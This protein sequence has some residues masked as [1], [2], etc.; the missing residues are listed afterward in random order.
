MLNYNMETKLANEIINCIYHHQSRPMF[1]LNKLTN[2]SID[3]KYSKNIYRWLTYG[4]KKLY[5]NIFKDKRNGVYYIGLREDNGIWCGTHLMAVACNGTSAKTFSYPTNIT[6]KWEDVSV[7]FWTRYLRMGKR[8]F[9]KI[10]WTE[11][12]KI[13]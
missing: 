3:E 4:N 10:W 7:K 12:N 8:G 11:K 13:K 2:P 9:L 5:T 6:K 1:G